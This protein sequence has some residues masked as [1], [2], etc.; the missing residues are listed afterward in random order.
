L[1]VVQEGIGL[2]QVAVY[3]VNLAGVFVARF[4]FLKKKIYS[5]VEQLALALALVE[6]IDALLYR[7]KEGGGGTYNFE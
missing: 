5:I 2:S 7:T 4:G 3:Q 6:L 1:N